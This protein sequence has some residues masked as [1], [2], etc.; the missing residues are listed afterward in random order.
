MAAASPMH[1]LATASKPATSKQRSTIN[2][3]KCH[4]FGAQLDFLRVFVLS[5]NLRTRNYPYF[6][7][8]SVLSP[9]IS[10]QDAQDAQD[11]DSAWLMP[12]LMSLTTP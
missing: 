3:C 5:R 9:G 2:D 8:T 12:S 10:I 6:P 1:G 7:R 11:D 4:T